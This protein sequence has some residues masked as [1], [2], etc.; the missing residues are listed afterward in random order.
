MF[1]VST[2]LPYDSGDDQ[3]IARKKHIGNDVVVFIFKMGSTPFNPSAYLSEFN[4][5]FI[6]VKPSVNPEGVKGFTVAVVSKVKND[7]C[8]ES[9]IQIINC[10]SSCFQKYYVVGNLTL[11]FHLTF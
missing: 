6:V 4:H 9:K 5:I 7:D 10:F 3:H 2:R 8:S 11:F 1:H